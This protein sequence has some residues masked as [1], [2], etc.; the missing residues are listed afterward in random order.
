MYLPFMIIFV[1]VVSIVIYI[2][3]LTTATKIIMNGKYII[4]PEPTLS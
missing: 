1:A 4:S 3:M 2:T